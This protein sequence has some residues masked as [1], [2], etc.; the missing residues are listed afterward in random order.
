M[1]VIEILLQL[2]QE[3]RLILIVLW[4]LLYQNNGTP[5]N[6]TIDDAWSISSDGLFH[7]RLIPT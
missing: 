3:K 6:K 2:S 5:T 1:G 7:Q 4:F